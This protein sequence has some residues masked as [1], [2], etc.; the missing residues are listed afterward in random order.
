MRRYQRLI[1]HGVQGGGNVCG[2]VGRV[3]EAG[4]SA[5]LETGWNILDVVVGIAV[6]V[7]RKGVIW[8]LDRLV[9]N[10]KNG[11]DDTAFFNCLAFFRGVNDGGVVASSPTAA[12]VKRFG[13]GVLCAVGHKENK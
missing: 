2:R 1:E 12:L 3:E 5:A 6:F 10:I 9:G 8:I 13:L 11:N 4:R 7:I